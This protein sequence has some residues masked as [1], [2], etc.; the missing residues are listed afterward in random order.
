VVVQ[1]RPDPQKELASD[2][3]LADELRVAKEL[4]RYQTKLK[5]R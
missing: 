3:D 5:H 2:I 1:R 4:Y